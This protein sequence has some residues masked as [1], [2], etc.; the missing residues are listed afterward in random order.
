[1]MLSKVW[2]ASPGLLAL[3]MC[4]ECLWADF[5]EGGIGTIVRVRWWTILRGL[6]PLRHRANSWACSSIN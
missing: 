3:H 6:D 1:M 2:Y 4:S 5:S